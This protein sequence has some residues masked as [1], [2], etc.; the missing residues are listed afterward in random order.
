MRRI[1]AGASHLS[2]DQKGAWRKETSHLSFGRKVPS[3]DSVDWQFKV[4]LGV[5]VVFGLLPYA[6]KE[7]PHWVTWSGIAIGVALVGWGLIPSHERF[8][9]GPVV[10]FIAGLTFMVGAAGW[11]WDISQSGDLGVEA[12]ARLSEFGWTVKPGQDGIQ[13]EIMNKPLPPMKESATYFGQLKKP[14]DLHFQSISGLEGLHYFA[15]I[16]GCTK[17]EINAGE[18]TDLSELRGFIQLTNLGISQLPLNGN[19][20]VD[21]SPLAPLINLRQLNLGMVRAKTIEALA[22]LKNLKSLNLGQTLIA[23]V[24]PISGLTSL[25]SLD[26]RGT[27]VTD[28]RPLVQD[29][30]LRELTIGGAQLPSL[31]NLA[32]LPNLKKISIIEQQGTD[33]SAIGALTNLESLWIWGGSAPLDVLPLRS[34]TKL[35][36]LTITGFGFGAL[37]AVLNI[38]VLGDLTE[39]R[40]LTFG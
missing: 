9:L 5:A 37:T 20:T 18:F 31:V 10:V 35:R 39:L 4:G 8:P 36:A 33:L 15:D 19:D 23:D 27:R 17:I 7:M 11:Y 3:E 1:T 28:L 22:T 14:F 24:S 6:V 34:L 16:P 2:G 32:H 38:Q 30:D 12:V 40:T 13:F 26:I 25:E 21:L 29:Q